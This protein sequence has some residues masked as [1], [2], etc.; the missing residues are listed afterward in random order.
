MSYTASKCDLMVRNIKILSFATP[1]FITFMGK[2]I[3]SLGLKFKVIVF[4]FEDSIVSI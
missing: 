4:N 1:R 2:V 3:V